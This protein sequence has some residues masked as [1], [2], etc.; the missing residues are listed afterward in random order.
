MK[1]QTSFLFIF[2]FC[3]LFAY[4]QVTSSDAGL[5]VPQDG[6]RNSN[7][8]FAS[9]EFRHGVQ[10]YYKGSYNEA[11]MQFEKALSFLPN[12]SLILEW[13]GK[14][15]YKSGMEG[16]A[17]AYWQ[18]AKNNGYGGLLLE[19]KIEVVRE[20]RV[21]GE[22]N[23]A[24]IRLTEAGSFDGNFNDN[25]VFSGPVSVLPNFDGTLW[26][27]S[28]NLNQLLLMNQNGIV[29]QRV[30]GPINGFDRPSDIIRLADNKLLVSENAGDRLALLSSKGSF[31]KY[32]GEKGRKTGQM[33]GPLYLAQ[34][35]FERIYVTDY[36]NRRVDVFDKDGNALFFFGGKSSDFAGLKGPTGI[37]L[38]NDSVFVADD[39]NGCIYE[40]DRSGNYV[41][42][43]VEKGTFSKPES[44]K[45]WNGAL[46]LCDSNKLISVDYDTGAI[47]EYARTGNAPSRVTCAS[48]D[49]NGNVLVCD[50]TSNELYIMSKLQELVG[51]L[52]VQIEAVDAS[53]FPNVVVEVKVENRHRQSL[54]GLQESNFYFTENKRPV[55]N[56][57][58]LGASSNNTNADITFIIDRSNTTRAY[59]NEIESSI[60]EIT[61]TLDDS[62]IVRIISAGEIPV[63]EYQGKPSLLNNFSLDA[64]KNPFTSK[65]N[66]DLALRL[67]SNDLI[68]GNKKRSILFISDCNEDSIDYSNYDLSE[69]TAFLNNNSISF[70]MIQLEQKAADE[71][72]DFILS[73]TFGDSYYVYRPAGLRSVVNDIL[74]MPQ[75]VYQFSYTSSLTTN[76]GQNYLP[77][78]AEVYLLNRSGRDEAGY[79]APLQ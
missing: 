2:S 15:Y 31:E 29:L 47:F 61:S 55:N 69:L 60:K 62:F 24:Q 71:K 51:G 57:K 1:K 10:A 65:I 49:I 77:L 21:T 52:F 42:A 19:N 46:L 12:D 41:R 13:L 16:S 23:E 33:V 67:A 68:K 39:Q 4:S 26:L 25:L 34:D 9:Q 66:L 38:V 3:L 28:Y 40:F 17:L 44:I 14:A 18:A 63:L 37:C 76:F 8:G 5:K 74:Q 70:S 36:G 6:I 20:R 59:K 79:F 35:E 72:L 50:Y 45:L 48:G 78:E 7:Q 75:G 53:K 32:I 73:N 30:T 64:L 43:L 11:I 58:L 22:S 54:V 56:F 27:A